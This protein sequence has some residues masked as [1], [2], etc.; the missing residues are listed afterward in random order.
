MLFGKRKKDRIIEW[1]REKL[2][3]V[4]RCSICNGEQVFGFQD[5]QTGEFREI[6]LIRDNAELSEMAGRYGIRPEEIRKVY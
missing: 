5:R 6:G 1:D 3:P 2:Q 4:L